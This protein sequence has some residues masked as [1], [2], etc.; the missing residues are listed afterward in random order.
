MAVH[1]PVGAAVDDV[2]VRGAPYQGRMPQHRPIGAVSRARAKRR[3]RRCVRNG[4]RPLAHL[5]LPEERGV[6]ESTIAFVP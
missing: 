5:A 1:A 2:T 4:N 6:S 3:V